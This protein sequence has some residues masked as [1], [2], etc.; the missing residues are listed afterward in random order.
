MRYSTTHKEQTRQKLVE[1]S[2]AIAKHGGFSATGVAGLMKAIGLTGGAFYN[3][4]ASKDDLFTE[5]VRHE[6]SNSQIGLCSRSGVL[7][8]E[9][10]ER[11]LDQY[12]SMAHLRNPESGCAIPAL[13]AEV[14]RAAQPVKEEAEQWL[15]ALQQAWAAILEDPQLA[16]ALLCQCVGALLVARMLAQEQ[17]QEEV[18]QASRSFLAKALET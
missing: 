18:L 2:G 17:S 8:R 15:R 6:L 14:A 5:V 10:L 9:K 1:S 16:W 12:L 11:C 7:S 4:F 3:H 13:G